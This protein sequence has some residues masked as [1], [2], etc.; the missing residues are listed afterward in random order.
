MDLICIDAKEVVHLAAPKIP[1][2]G[3]ATFTM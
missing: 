2:D 3:V 1:V